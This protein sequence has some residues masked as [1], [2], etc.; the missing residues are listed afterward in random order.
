MSHFTQTDRQTAATVGGAFTQKECG[1]FPW[2]P[3]LLHTNND[4]H[5]A[6]LILVGVKEHI[7]CIGWL[8]HT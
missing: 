1:K 6:A 5:H 3:P 7:L 4:T 8:C 2:T